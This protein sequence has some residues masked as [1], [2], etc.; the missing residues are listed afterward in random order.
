MLNPDVSF[1]TEDASS[2]SSFSKTSVIVGQ[3]NSSS[4]GLFKDLELKNIDEIDALFGAG[5]HLASLLRDAVTMMSDSIVKPKLWAVNYHDKSDAVAR[6]V[7][8]A[9]SGTATESKVLK[10]RLNGGNPNR[11][12]VQAATALALRN[13]KGA[14]C[15]NFAQNAIEF[16][17][18]VNARRAFNPILD[19]FSTN[20]VMVEVNIDR[21]SGAATVAEV[22]TDAINAKLQSLFSA[23]LD[24]A[25]IMLTAK[26][27]GSLGQNFTIEIM[28]DSI[29]TGIAFSITEDTE[30]TGVVDASSILSISD[31]YDF[32]LRD[33]DFNYIVLPYGYSIDSL[34]TDAKAKLDNVL[35]YNNRC[36]EYHVFRGTAIDLNSDEELDDLAGDEPVEAIGVVKTLFLMSEV[37]FSIKPVIKR[38]F[39]KAIE[40]KQFTPIQYDAKNGDI[41]VGN[42]YTLSNSIGFKNI[43][44]LLA[45]ELVREVIVEKFMPSDFP[46]S[47]FTTGDNVDS[48]TY[49]K[50][51]IVSKFQSYRDILDGSNVNS[52]YGKDFS[53]I[54]VSS[55][56]AR[57]R[58][59]ELL[60]V[61][62]TFDKTTKQVAL[63]LANE[64]TNPLKSIFI[65]SSYQ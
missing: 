37:G 41:T 33:L 45:A 30:G 32:E 42:C 50:D 64:L 4:E 5:S 16:G 52:V 63:K 22:V 10:I 31:N 12:A 57:A 44:R 51:S 65:I 11:V 36:L 19:D 47:D 27:K 24:S 35:D 17:A 29:A 21:G 23:E 15:G 54:V 6:I 8:V 1:L 2:D 56:E 55:A 18:P 38:T 59:D 40:N 3:A 43:E 62:V 20:D 28:P 58:F 13:T 14:Y 53:N 60:N 26:H 9:A 48:T 34:V 61:S 25:N 7:R 46:E 39:R 49:N